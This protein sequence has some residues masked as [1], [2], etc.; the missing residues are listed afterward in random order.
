VANQTYTKTLPFLT[1]NYSVNREWSAYAQVAKGFLVPDLSMFYVNNPGLNTPKPQTSTNYQLGTVHQSRDL[2][3]DADV[4]YIDFND[5]IA[6]T[7]NGNDLVFFNQGGW[8][9]R[10]SKRPR[11]I[12]WAAASRC[13]RMVR[14][15]AP[16]PRQRPAGVEG[17][18]EHGCAGL[19]VQGQRR[20]RLVDRQ[21]GRRP[22]RQ[23]RR[24]G[25]LQD[26]RL[27]HRRPDAGLALEAE[28][29]GVQE[30][31]AAAGG[32]QPV[33]KQDV[34]SISAN[35]KGAAFDQ[36]TFVPSAA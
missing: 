7:G 2:S 31:Q 10:A 3:F 18:E 29:A 28:R 30:R 15:T 23:G 21:V 14:S 33:N 34:T 32:E 17:A 19:A 16:R 26:R 6:S 27:Y 4:Y 20:L 5:K 8:C 35:S 1:T 9:T 24:A 12:T 13:T 11:P 22:V 36:Y 25:R